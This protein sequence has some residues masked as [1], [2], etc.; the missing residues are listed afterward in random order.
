MQT[1]AVSHRYCSIDLMSFS[2]N[3]FRVSFSLVKPRWLCFV[4]LDMTKIVY[5]KHAIVIINQFFCVSFSLVKSIVDE[6]DKRILFV[7]VGKN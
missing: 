3:F 2:I 1:G 4:H 5:G 6:V 7:D